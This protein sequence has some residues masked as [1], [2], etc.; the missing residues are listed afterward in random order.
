MTGFANDSLA[1]Q[2]DPFYLNL[3]K[4]DWQFAR[5]EISPG[6][7]ALSLLEDHSY[8]VERV[9]LFWGDNSWFDSPIGLCE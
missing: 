1:V 3:C 2:F 7:E 9:Y 8:F 5:M 4:V 6:L